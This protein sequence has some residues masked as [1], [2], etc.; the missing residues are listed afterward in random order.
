LK[1]LIS[2]SDLRR[3]L[4]NQM[5]AYL[6]EGGRVQEIP[7]GISG[8]DSTEGP[9]PMPPFIGDEPREGRTYVNEVVAGIEA[10][11]K[12][13]APP[14]PKPRRPR[15]KIIYDDFGEPLRWVWEE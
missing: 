13:A 8:R 3:Q 10:R 1:P 6:I 2:K 4:E 11:R 15:K 12:A 14:K 7:R 9:L 5:R